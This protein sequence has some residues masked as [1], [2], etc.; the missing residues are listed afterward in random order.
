[1]RCF[2]SARLAEQRQVGTLLSCLWYPTKAEKSVA[3]TNH[4]CH[5]G[6]LYFA[7]SALPVSES[8][9][10]PKG[11]VEG[12]LWTETALVCCLS[13]PIAEFHHAFLSF[14]CVEGVWMA[15]RYG[16]SRLD[17][18]IRYVHWGVG[19][20]TIGQ[21]TVTAEVGVARSPT[22]CSPLFLKGVAH[23]PIS[24]HRFHFWTL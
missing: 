2:A 15:Q 18:Q 20:L 23:F 16:C 8:A 19:E 17:V 3:C 14:S 9:G 5:C 12:C 24:Q 21:I 6:L 10:W 1:V 13:E 22:H 4:D 7:G 11:G